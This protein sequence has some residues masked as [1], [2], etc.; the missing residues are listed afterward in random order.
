M[1][2][3]VSLPE[4]N[5]YKDGRKS[6]WSHTAAVVGWEGETI[7]ETGYRIWD[8]HPGKVWHFSSDPQKNTV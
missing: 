6:R 3:N 5:L 7:E 4:G 2:D 1:V 8:I